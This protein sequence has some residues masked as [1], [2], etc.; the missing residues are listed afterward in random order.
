MKY[1]SFLFSLIILSTISYAQPGGRG[2]RNVDPAERAKR[3]TE[4][5]TEQLALTE[6]QVPM[7]EE[8]NQRY[9]VKMGEEREKNM[10]D[11]EAMRAA[12]KTLRTSQNEEFQAILTDEQYTKLQEFQ[13]EQQERRGQGRQGGRKGGKKKNEQLQEG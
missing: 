9:A 12:M 7:I 13:K 6:D 10:G 8:I 3:Q 11:R 1:L 2:D 4:T 5:M